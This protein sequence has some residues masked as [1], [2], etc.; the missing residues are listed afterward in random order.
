MI[1]PRRQLPNA[2]KECV[3]LPLFLLK[4]CPFVG[5]PFVSEIRV[6]NNGKE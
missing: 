5:I 2:L 4:R 3:E 6:A 1:F